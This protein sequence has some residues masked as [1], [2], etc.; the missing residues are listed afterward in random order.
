MYLGN[1]SKVQETPLLA[2]LAGLNATSYIIGG[3]GGV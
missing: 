1:F 2:G 3:F